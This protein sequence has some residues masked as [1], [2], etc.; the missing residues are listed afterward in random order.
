[1]V[2]SIPSSTHAVPRAAT[3][4]VWNGAQ[5]N[6]SM[7]AGIRLLMAEPV[8][9][10]VVSDIPASLSPGAWRARWDH[11][12]ASGAREQAAHAIDDDGTSRDDARRHL[13]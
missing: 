2:I 12:A 4:R 6:L 1:M 11:A 5:C 9:L 7:R 13:G 8:A 3:I 10:S